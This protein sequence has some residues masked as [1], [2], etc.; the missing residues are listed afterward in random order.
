[1]DL[2]TENWRND[3]KLSQLAP[4]LHKNVEYILRDED[5]DDQDESDFEQQELSQC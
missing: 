4:I 3:P 2:V 5:V 1:M